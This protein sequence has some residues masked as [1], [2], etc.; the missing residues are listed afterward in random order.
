MILQ[1][2]AAFGVGTITGELVEFR[3]RYIRA[4]LI[5]EEVAVHGYYPIEDLR[6]VTILYDD[7][8]L[9]PLAGELG[10]AFWGGIDII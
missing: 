6:E 5:V 3:G 9:V 7:L 10:S 2:D 4:P 1:G 8:K